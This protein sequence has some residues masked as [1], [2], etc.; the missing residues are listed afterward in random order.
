MRR[1]VSRSALVMTSLGGIVLGAGLT[2]IYEPPASQ[3]FQVEI[4]CF[5]GGHM[6]FLDIA[7]RREVS[8]VGGFVT[9]KTT[10]GVEFAASGDCVVVPVGYEG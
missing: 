1:L 4:S 5:S 6:T 10:D 7:D 9:G 2:S 8:I 3:S